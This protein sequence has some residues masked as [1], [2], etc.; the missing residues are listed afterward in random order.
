MKRFSTVA[1]TA[2][3]VLL[4]GLKFLMPQVGAE[5][6][7][8]FRL[9]MEREMGYAETFFQLNAGMKQGVAVD[10]PQVT[11]PQQRPRYL[12]VSVTTAPRPEPSPS[13]TPEPTPTPEPSPEPTPEPLPAAVTAFLESQAA[14]SD[15]ELPEKA[16]YSYVELPFDY[17]V[18]VSGYNSSGYGFRLHPILNTV[19]FH[20]GTDF[21]AYAGEP[22]LAFAEGTVCYAGYDE[23]YGWHIK[24]D[25]GD[26]WVTLYAHC[27][28][29]YAVEGQTVSPGDCI[30]LV[31]STGLATGPHLHFELTRDGKYLNPEYY[32]N[33]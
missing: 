17:A 7:D 6:R 13:P 18:P 10:A 30:A 5:L 12:Y 3:L 14:F 9:A 21:A 31:G 4:T 8:K 33:S 2:A 20:Y 27:S 19:R 28:K 25:H 22:V 1:A 11:A 26:G 16:D 15:Y 23:S 32:I 29:L 24:I